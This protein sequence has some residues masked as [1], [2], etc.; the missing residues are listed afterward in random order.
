MKK[1]LTGCTVNKN[2]RTAVINLILVLGL[3][4]ALLFPSAVTARIAVDHQYMALPLDYENREL[5]RSEPRYLV[6]QK[7]A[8][9][10]T[11][12]EAEA[13]CLSEF[14]TNI[15][16]I[17]RWEPY[18]DADI[19]S[20][21]T[22][23]TDPL[24]DN[25]PDSCIDP[26][27]SLDDSVRCWGDAD[28]DGVPWACDMCLLVDDATLN[29]DPS[30]CTYPFDA[31]LGTEDILW[32]YKAM[33]TA[34]AREQG[35]FNNPASV[36]SLENCMVGLGAMGAGRK[37][38]FDPE[39]LIGGL[40]T[41]I[42]NVSNDNPVVI[43]APGYSSYYAFEHQKI[44]DGSVIGIDNVYQTTVYTTTPSNDELHESPLNGN[45][46]M[47]KNGVGDTF[48]LY[49][50]DGTTP[51]DGSTL[52][53]YSPLKPSGFSPPVWSW[54][55][56]ILLKDAPGFSTAFYINNFTMQSDAAA[57]YASLPWSGGDIAVDNWCTIVDIKG[58]DQAYLE[59]DLNFTSIVINGLLSSTNCLGNGQEAPY[60]AIC[61]NPAYFGP[62]TGADDDG[63]EVPDAWD[64]CPPSA[65][66]IDADCANND[67]KNSDIEDAVAI[68]RFDELHWVNEITALDTSGNNLHG[69]RIGASAIPGNINGGLYFH[70]EDAFFELGGSQNPI[71]IF[72][73][74][75]DAPLKGLPC[76][77]I[78]YVRSQVTVDPNNTGSLELTDGTLMA[79][80]KP[81]WT[82]PLPCGHG[83][84]MIMGLQ[85]WDNTRYSLHVKGDY[86]G[87]ELFNG[88]TTTSFTGTTISS[89][90]WQHVAITMDSGTAR[91]YLNGQPLGTAQSASFGTATGLPF[92]IG[93][94]DYP[95]IGSG[96]HVFEGGIDEVAVFNKALS[97]SEIQNIYTNGLGDGVGDACTDE[98]TAGTDNCDTNA[99]CTDTTTG[100][101]CACDTG[102]SGDGETCTDIDEC[103]AGTDNCDANATCTDTDGSFTCACNTGYSGDGVTC[104]ED[105]DECTAGTDNCDANA[106]CTDTTTG[107][108]CTCNTG[109]SGD[110]V[111]CTL[112]DQCP[113][114]PNKTEPGICGCGNADTDSDGDGIADCIDNCPSI[115]NAGQA[116][117]DGDNVG[118][119]CD[120]CVDVSN[121]DQRD[122]N[123][124]EDD[125]T[126]MAGEQHYGNACDPDFDNDGLVSLH[127]FI[128]WR[129]YFRQPVSTE[130]E[131]IDLNGNGFIDLTD[132][133]IWRSYFRNTPGPG[134]SDECSP[135]P[136]QNGGTCTD[137]INSYTCE[138]PPGYE[139]TNC[140]TNI[141]ECTPNPCQ[142]GGTCTD[143]INSYTCE[144]P[145]GYEGMNCIIEIDECA[146][147][148]DGN[149][150]DVN[151]FC[152]N[153]PGSFECI[154]NPG[155]TGDGVSC[156]DENE[157]L[158]EGYGNNCD[159]NAA[160]VNTPGNFECICNPGYTGNGVSC[161]D[162]NECIGEGDGNNC[163][164]NAVC[165]NTPGSFECVCIPGYTGDGVT[166]VPE[167][168][169]ICELGE[170]G[171]PDC[172]DICE[173]Q[174]DGTTD[175]N[176]ICEPEEGE[177]S[178]CFGMGAPGDPCFFNL[179]CF[180]NYCDEMTGVCSDE[181]VGNGI[182]ELGE[183]G[184]PECN[185]ICE[186]QEDG[187]SDCNEICE[188]EEGESSDCLGM[189]AP[190]DPCSFHG[191]CYNNYCDEICL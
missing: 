18:V 154:C 172:N 178:D 155:Y 125:N 124:G 175:C 158:E 95:I 137:G 17:H 129:I 15:A 139:G 149:D 32:Q 144:C 188:P 151:A 107:F 75:W 20:D 10:M 68:W 88:T 27:G 102:Y 168:N 41:F 133:S 24:P 87:L 81:N 153:T 103:T 98:C 113:S 89:D 73:P 161:L 11:R 121:S 156:L 138:C 37:W 30:N 177:S 59:Q 112:I 50:W 64:N 170:E 128:Q 135:N 119:I 43:T 122:T 96:H 22:A 77:H 146:G 115:P 166:C 78:Q 40:Q 47:V 131:D 54:N 76:G 140:E 42:T 152:V 94:G 110:G 69:E 71:S 8:A 176:G 104:T 31:Y 79:W 35:Y 7:S 100:F 179:D 23:C 105:I 80:I 182:C 3:L 63:D 90:T 86:S 25:Y 174:E 58:Q 106:S 66:T 12:V 134:T 38:Y 127:D 92:H 82:T 55:Y 148:G 186:E 184:T 19:I 109:Y 117:S 29:G 33:V 49:S 62:C 26:G 187:T 171:T 108:T 190:G 99:S 142:N 123:A 145:Q 136:C 46:F 150:C 165:A 2:R 114:D 39:N 91:A 162:E 173:V 61:D 189:G 83:V 48:E 1:K 116:D 163:D 44:S 72:S 141:N 70:L 180:S 16:T 53:Y 14:K 36:D 34:C 21:T 28:G 6:T 51:V 118:D 111:T 9:P 130:S 84:P 181:P 45:R 57:D 167:S 52:G 97:Q 4:A 120:N 74:L 5:C 126:A 60:Y 56:L 65:C 132:F 101:T 183:E 185:N 164:V 147:E 191:E 157:C 93:T 159:A 85:D 67:Q 143:G 160:C 169:G 13:A